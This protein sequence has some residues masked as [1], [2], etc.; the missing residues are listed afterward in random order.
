M[1][2][3]IRPA[4]NFGVELRYQ[5]VRWS[6]FV[7]LNELSDV[8]KKRVHV[9]L[10]RTCEKLSVVLTDMLSEKVESVLNVRHGGFLWRECQAALLEEGPHQGFDFGCQDLFG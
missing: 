5:P 7:G 2:V 6:L 3:I 4:A 10:R 8:R 9:F 1:L